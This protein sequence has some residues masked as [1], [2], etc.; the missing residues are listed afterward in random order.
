MPLIVAGVNHVTTPIDI[1]ERFAFAAAETEPALTALAALDSVSEAVLLSTCNRTEVYC[2]TSGGDGGELIAWMHRWHRL[3]AGVYDS[4]FYRRFDREAIAHLLGVGAGLDSLVLGE[5]QIGGQIKQAWQA[6]RQAGTAGTV[7]DRAFQ[8]AFRTAKR[9]RAET[10][11]GRNP[12]T[13][14]YAAVA[15]A[16]QIFD[17]LPARHAL[18]LGAGDMIR[19][20]AGYL[21]QQGLGRLTVVNRDAERAGEL[22]GEFTA[23]C[24]AGLDALPEVLREAD[25]VIAS[26]A[27]PEPLIDVAL[28]RRARAGRRQP[29]LMIDIAVP[30]DIAPEVADLDDV[31]LYTIDDLQEVIRA[32]LAERTAATDD[33]RL[34]VEQETAAFLRWLEIRRAQHRLATY[35]QQAETIRDRTLAE[36][37]RRLAAGLEADAALDLLAGRLTQRLLHGPSRGL[38]A[39]AG[40][41]DHS[42]VERLCTLLL[43]APEG[44]DPDSEAETNHG[45]RDAGSEATPNRRR[46]AS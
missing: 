3:P 38:R 23:A 10:A 43:E 19:L 41:G 5:P 13:V 4:H 9:V 45:T 29:L 16:R 1:R 15:L 46:Q 37:R 11:I 21:Q 31:F 17:D 2:R 30:R 42:L 12:V 25:L 20:S 8:A 7:L 14:P 18:L 32:G 35:R 39:L 27:S 36:V 24:G 6:A 34:I 26:T 44:S 28:L 33:A 22:A 40:S